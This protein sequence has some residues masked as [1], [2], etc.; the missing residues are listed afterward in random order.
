MSL[1]M[2]ACTP[3]AKHVLVVG[4][5]AALTFGSLTDV[6]EGAPAPKGVVPDTTRISPFHF[7]KS[8]RFTPEYLLRAAESV[9]NRSTTAAE[10]PIE[11]TTPTELSAANYAKRYGISR[12]LAQKIVDVALAEGVDPELGFRLIRAESRF[13][14]NARGPG[15][16]LGLLQLMPGTARSLD[17]SLRTDAQILE[18]STNLRLGLRYLRRMIDRYDG[19]VRLGLLAYNRGP[20]AVDRALKNGR[21]PENGYTRKVLGSGGAAYRGAGLL[22]K[23]GS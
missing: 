8:V 11:V 9:S 19:D 20:V 16:S 18:P 22:P 13:V 17:R 1:G 10:I 3:G 7:Q 14:V 4:T 2:T 15:G 5:L 6:A 23:G 12:D 21:N